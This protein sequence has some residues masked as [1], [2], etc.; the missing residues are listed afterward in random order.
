[1]HGL[2]RT[3]RF[4]SQ[5]CQGNAQE[6]Q[7]GSG[8]SNTCPANPRSGDNSRRCPQSRPFG[9]TFASQQEPSATKRA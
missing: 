4:P 6:K 2:S 5:R 8:D 9:K 3:L 7:D 1:M